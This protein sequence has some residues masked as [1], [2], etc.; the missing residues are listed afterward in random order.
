[1]PEQF[2]VHMAKAKVTFG[3]DVETKRF[4][5]DV[6]GKAVDADGYVVEK[7]NHAQRVLTPDGEEVTVNDF[8]GLHKG[9]LVFVKSDLVSTIQMADRLK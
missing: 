6:F 9:S 7:V 3:S 4:I 2:G 5:L 1:M 8:A